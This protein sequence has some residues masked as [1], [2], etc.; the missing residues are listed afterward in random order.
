MATVLILLRLQVLVPLD[1]K[2]H[3]ITYCS[4]T[5][6]TLLLLQLSG[7]S[8]RCLDQEVLHAVWAGR[9]NWSQKLVLA[10]RW[11]IW[12]SW[13]NCRRKM[14]IDFS[15]TLWTITKVS[16]KWRENIFF[17]TNKKSA[18]LLKLQ[19]HHFLLWILQELLPVFVIIT[20]NPTN[21]KYNLL[22]PSET[23][24]HDLRID[25]LATAAWKRM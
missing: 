8:N 16:L 17:S 5:L 7:D 24:K 2:G 22:E 9:G 10:H 1:C 6:S 18:L 14:V 3:C 4:T 25:K 23:R 20:R 11:W 12:R 19:Q 21:W 15:W 13:R